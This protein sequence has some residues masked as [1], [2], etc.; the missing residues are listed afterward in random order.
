MESVEEIHRHFEVTKHG[1]F[2]ESAVPEMESNLHLQTPPL[3]G[4]Q[5][6]VP[7]IYPD[8]SYRCNFL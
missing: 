2:N 6:T 5:T 3:S 8:T 1:S 4:H 7:E